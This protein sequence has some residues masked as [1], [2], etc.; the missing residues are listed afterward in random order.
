[1]EQTSNEHRALAALSLSLSLSY[2]NTF[3]A[4]ILFA[5][6]NDKDDIFF[7]LTL[8]LSSSHVWWTVHNI[9]QATRR[10]RVGGKVLLISTDTHTVAESKRIDLFHITNYK[11]LLRWKLNQ[12]IAL[13]S[14][15]VTN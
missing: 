6:F 3:D 11:I 9:I 14:R 10:G 15:L 8:A 5:K 2:N 7:C 12:K 4:T 1:M 13:F